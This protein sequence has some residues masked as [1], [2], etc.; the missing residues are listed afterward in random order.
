MK[1]VEFLRITLYAWQLTIA[2]LMTVTYGNRRQG[3]VVVALLGERPQA[4][5]Y[6]A[7]VG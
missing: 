5:I 4:F 7:T 2:M 6:Y 3:E 1:G